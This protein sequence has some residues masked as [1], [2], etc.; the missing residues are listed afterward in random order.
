MSALSAPR[1]Q[2]G[3]MVR[4]A[5]VMGAL[6]AVWELC[7]RAM[8]GTFV[9]APPSD[10]IAHFAQNAGLY[11]RATGVTLAHAA[12]GFVIGN[13]VAVTL[14]FAAIAWPRSEGVIRA[15]ALVVFCLPLVATGPIL[16]VL[17][18][19]GAGPQITLAALAV[20]YTTL[21]PLLVGLRA[22]PSAWLDLVASY[23]R[24]RGTEILVVRARASLPYLFAS[25]QIAAP[26]AFLGAMIGEFTGAERGLGVLTLQAMRALDVNATWTIATLAASV[27]V[28]SHAAIGALGDRLMPDRPSLILSTPAGAA[29]RWMDTVVT[30]GATTL[31]ILVVWWGS[32]A[33]A[34]L[35]S[36]FAKRPGHVWTFLTTDPDALGDLLAAMAQTAAWAVP[37]YLAGL[38]LGAGLACLFLLAPATATAFLPIAIALRA[39]PIITT[40][41]VI[42]LALGR[43]ASGTIT[44][45][46]TMIFFPTLVA[47]MQGLRQVPGQVIDL[48][49]SYAAHATTT[50]VLARL[51][52]MLPAFFAAARMAVP[53]AILAVTVAEWLAT[54]TGI[55]AL[56][57]L[58]ASLSDF[59]LLWSAVVVLTLASTFAYLAVGAVEH[60]VLSRFAPEQVRA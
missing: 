51:P 28:A 26:A 21:V 25:L 53:A 34:D 3:L 4:Q 1:A 18:G 27:S 39:I 44:I 58:S 46:A 35:S 6:L 17:W 56:M 2:I 14:A 42:V 55:G 7:G 5:L 23:G 11:L 8:A 52:A 19:P 15:L 49:D 41:P 38:V 10:I 60:A 43:G 30:A 32:M 54:G 13:A 33:L 40:A 16:R 45:V 31:V 29:R 9:F 47:C 20:Y 48:F 12:T 57:A 59:N 24:G 37:G 36:F 22:M 50:L